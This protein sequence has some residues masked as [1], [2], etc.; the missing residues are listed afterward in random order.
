MVFP[1]RSFR[2]L[3]YPRNGWPIG[4]IDARNTVTAFPFGAEINFFRGLDGHDVALTRRRSQ[5]QVLSE[6]YF[7]SNAP[8]LLCFVERNLNDSATPFQLSL[9][10]FVIPLNF[11]KYFISRSSL[12][13]MAPYLY[14]TV[15]NFKKRSWLLLWLRAFFISL[16]AQMAERSVR[17]G[18]FGYPYQRRLPNTILY[19]EL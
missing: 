18:C 12:S 14:Y 19:C 6:A 5:V 2:A 13:P 1:I 7:S 9:V 15:M 17:L 3:S 10:I 16:T 11:G 4:V 8:Y